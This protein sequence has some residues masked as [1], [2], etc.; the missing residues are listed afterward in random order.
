[1]FRK[2]LLN[3]K[4]HQATADR[5]NS[6]AES[7]A[8][9]RSDIAS[10]LW[11]AGHGIPCCNDPAKSAKCCPKNNVRIWDWICPAAFFMVCAGPTSAK[12]GSPEMLHSFCGNRGHCRGND[13]C[14]RC[15]KN[16]VDSNFLL[17]SASGTPWINRLTTW[18]HPS[19]SMM[20]Q[21][22]RS[23][24]DPERILS[25]RRTI[26]SEEAATMDPASFQNKDPWGYQIKSTIEHW[27][28]L[29]DIGG[30][31]CP[32]TLSWCL[33]KNKG[34]NQYDLG[35]DTHE[36]SVPNSLSHAKAM[37]IDATDQVCRFERGRLGSQQRNSNLTAVLGLGSLKCHHDPS[38]KLLLSSSEASNTTLLS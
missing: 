26:S 8:Q 3:I 14:L 31:C 18:L 20:R 17:L 7:R 32:E 9:R 35:P 29:M 37:G 19:P 16:K 4:T 38:Y 25:T 13:S 1:M 12:K 36:E 2:I 23:P 28:T 5:R 11:N 33:Q 6:G 15:L 10:A 27:W 24:I 22:Q 21:L 30:H 34:L